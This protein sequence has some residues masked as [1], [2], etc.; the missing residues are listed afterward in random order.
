MLGVLKI[1]TG[2]ERNPIPERFRPSPQSLFYLFQTLCLV[3]SA[4]FFMQSNEDFFEKK[5]FRFFSPVTHSVIKGSRYNSAPPASNQSV[6]CHHHQ[7]HK[8][9]TFIC[10][11]A[12]HFFQYAKLVLR[13]I[14]KH[15]RFRAS[16]FV[17]IVCS[18]SDFVYYFGL[19]EGIKDPIVRPTVTNNQVTFYL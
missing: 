6:C 8:T 18:F 14:P 11:E 10:A 12:V 19:I 2:S 7:V 4:H 9:A 16:R 1:Q 15:H 17:N 13:N 3:P 5:K